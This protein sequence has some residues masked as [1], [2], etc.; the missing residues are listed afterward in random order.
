MGVLPERDLEGQIEVVRR[1]IAAGYLV[2]AHKAHLERLLAEKSRIPPIDEGEPK[3]L[4]KE[5]YERIQALKLICA[6]DPGGEAWRPHPEWV[7]KNAEAVLEAC[8]SGR[9]QVK[10]GMVSYWFRGQQLCEPK[11]LDDDELTAV[12]AAHNG[13]T[14][15]FWVEDP[16]PVIQQLAITIPPSN[17]HQLH[18]GGRPHQA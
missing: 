18:L 5:V 16:T 3:G 8:R 17:Q 11:P 4:T 12:A 2:D 10:P 15:E 9:L 7:I 13:H 6:S 14:G 1:K